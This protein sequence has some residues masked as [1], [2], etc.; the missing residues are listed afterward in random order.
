MYA[1]SERFTDA[2]EARMNALLS[3]AHAQVAG[4]ER[5][6][7]LNFSTTNTVFEDSVS[8]LKAL[9]SV[10]DTQGLMSLTAAS[11]QPTLDKA[12]GYS[13]SVYAVVK[14]SGARKAA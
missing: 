11:A 12:I 2:N 4:F 10:K 5:L 6:P 8:Q 7:A 14:N 1:T 9:L 3:I 13:R